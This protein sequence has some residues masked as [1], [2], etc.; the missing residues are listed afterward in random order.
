DQ[1]HHERNEH[2]PQKR[3]AVGNIHEH[4][5]RTPFAPRGTVSPGPEFSR[6]SPAARTGP[7]STRTEYKNPLSLAENEPV[8]A[9]VLLQAL[10]GSGIVEGN[11]CPARRQRID[12]GGPNSGAGR[13]SPADV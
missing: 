3:Q 1:P 9:E 6:F 2:D 5:S 12:L 4:A 13:Q 7:N 8:L 11:G 10:Q